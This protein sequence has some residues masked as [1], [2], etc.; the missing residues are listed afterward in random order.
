MLNQSKSVEQILN[1][2]RQ[3]EKTTFDISVT[4]I[5][6]VQILYGLDQLEKDDSS[7]I[8]SHQSR[9]D[10]PTKI[11]DTEKKVRKTKD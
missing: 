4:N 5:V 6:L 1:P 7:N 3:T 2:N 10:K 11:R 8:I 9:L